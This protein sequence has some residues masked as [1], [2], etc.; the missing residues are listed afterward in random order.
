MN[1]KGLE[2]TSA[3]V[4]DIAI[5]QIEGLLSPSPKSLAAL[6]DLVEFAQAAILNEEL[7]VTPA[8][9]EN[10]PSLAEFDFV[11][12]VEFEVTISDVD[13]APVEAQTDADEE[14]T[15]L[16]DL[17]E[18]GHLT[19]SHQ[20]GELALAI[21]NSMKLRNDLLFGLLANPG[22][23]CKDELFMQKTLQKFPVLMLAL[24]VDRRVLEY[25]GEEARRDMEQQ[26]GESISNYRAFAASMNALNQRWGMD[27]VLSVLEQP[28]AGTRMLDSSL[29]FAESTVSLPRLRQILGDEAMKV[30]GRERF[31][32]HWQ[33]PPLGIIALAEA[34]GIDE[35]SRVIQKARKKFA[36]LR[37]S[38]G[39]LRTKRAALAER[40]DFSSGSGERALR[41]LATF[42]NEMRAALDAM[43]TSLNTRRSRTELVFSTL[44]FALE[45]FGG[46]GVG[47]IGKV[48]GAVGLKQRAVMQRIPGLFRA[49]SFIRAGDDALV[50]D[51]VERLVGRAPGELEGQRFILGRGLEDGSRY[52]H[53]SPAH[54]PE[55]EIAVS[56]ESEGETIDVSDRDFWRFACTL[57]KFLD[58]FS[59]P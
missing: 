4:T 53:S 17:N 22:E 38:T 5:N 50:T 51:V 24:Q 36:K 34:K 57:D 18:D 29:E 32:E 8:A 6:I 13:E 39:E 31:F 59:F 56:I 23:I 47:T 49:E 26:L 44:D 35:V 3:F 27:T 16:I 12:P 41:E 9:Y 37:T 2:G 1:S 43:S 21:I 45:L 52:S 30:P 25:D 28:F 19:S 58:T 15:I 7:L 11:K 20:V 42:D 55:A 54:P 10:S 46:L 40:V 48:A 33:V 14:E